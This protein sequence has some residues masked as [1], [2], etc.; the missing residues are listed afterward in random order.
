ML[1]WVT[2]TREIK[3]GWLQRARSGEIS[4]HY[5]LQLIIVVS[6]TP[7]YHKI[8]Q[9]GPPYPPCQ[10]ASA[11]EKIIWN[12]CGRNLRIIPN[13]MKFKLVISGTFMA[14]FRNIVPKL[15]F[16]IL[17][18]MYVCMFLEENYPDFYPKVFGQKWSFVRSIPHGSIHRK[19]ITLI[20]INNKNG[21]KLHHSVS[22]T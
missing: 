11:P 4:R 12:S 8:R 19:R 6:C 2:S 15:L 13:L 7:R 14:A 9:M 1:D 17:R 16:I 3:T 21:S 20:I 18:F 5:T 22:L 10:N